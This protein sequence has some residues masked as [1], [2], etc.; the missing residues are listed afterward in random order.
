[1]ANPYDPSP[2][3][4]PYSSPSDYSLP[5]QNEYGVEKTV[6][7]DGHD[8]D[9]TTAAK[10]YNSFSPPPPVSNP[11]N[12]PGQGGYSNP[13]MGGYSN[14]NMGGYSNPNMMP[15]P[16]G[17][18]PYGPP[19]RKKHTTL[20]IVLGIVGGLVVLSL[21]GCVVFSA[22]VARDINQATDTANST[23][24]TPDQNTV[25]AT[26]T[27]SNLNSTPATGGN[28]N[29]NDIDTEAG[30]QLANVGQA[31]TMDGVQTSIDS[32][33]IIPGDSYDTPDA[34]YQFVEVH[35]TMKNNTSSG[36]YYNPFDFQIVTNG[37]SAGPAIGPDSVPE[38]S[39]LGDGTLGPGNTTQGD[40]VFQVATGDNNSVVTWDPTFDMN[41]VPYQWK[42]N[43]F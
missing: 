35:V 19:P 23:G 13:N 14:P 20:W 43:L 33:K 6:A 25:T 24:T 27:S 12:M 21:I 17:Y 18:P 4:D 36:Q 9:K 11:N 39:M 32:A 38:S 22:A 30:S 41:D 28:N 31:L 40:I 16:G 26:V 8:V 42:L 10:S 34:G 37:K 7:A 2:S 29:S 1:M 15:G 3:E 5:V